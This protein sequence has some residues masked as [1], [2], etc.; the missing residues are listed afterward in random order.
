MY[1]F[2]KPIANAKWDQLCIPPILITS[3]KSNGFSDIFITNYWVNCILVAF[4]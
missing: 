3:L 4:R 1:F 2:I